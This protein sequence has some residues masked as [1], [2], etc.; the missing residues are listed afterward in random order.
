M[1]GEIT[2]GK[3]TVVDGCVYMGG[4]DVLCKYDPARDRWDTPWSAPVD[5][6]GVG[7]LNNKPLVVGGRCN[8]KG[9]ADVYIFEEDSQQPWVRFEHPMPVGLAHVRVASH[10]S[11]LVVCGMPDV[12]SPARVL[13]YDIQSSEWHH[14]T[15]PVAFNS[16]YCS[17][18]FMNNKYYLAVG[19]EGV[20][21]SARHQSSPE[22]Y[23]QPLST[24][25]DPMCSQEPFTWQRMPDTP[26][27]RSH[28]AVTGGCLLAL[29]GYHNACNLLDNEDVTGNVAS[30]IH[31]YCPATTSWV[32]IGGLPGRRACFTT[33]TLSSGELF[34]AGGHIRSE[35]SNRLDMDK[36]VFTGII[37]CTP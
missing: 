15:P 1:P 23:C 18:V 26:C 35:E 37:K 11:A 22:V 20:F 2:V 12:L 31:V 36:K 33:S 8:E 9:V 17:G 19:A 28:L 25:L 29:G 27:H 7:N 30:E 5:A 34:I 14:R 4:A 3:T 13:V 16:V 10:G 21:G 32:K 24:L 6:F